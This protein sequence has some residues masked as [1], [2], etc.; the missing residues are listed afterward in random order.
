[1]WSVA[2][3]LFRK[4]IS[5]D[6]VIPAADILHELKIGIDNEMISI[7]EATNRYVRILNNHPDTAPI[8]KMVLH[9]G[10]LVPIVEIYRTS[11]PRISVY[12]GTG[13]IWEND[14]SATVHQGHCVCRH[15]GDCN[16][17]MLPYRHAKP[18]RSRTIQS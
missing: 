4:F 11:Y 2:R 7:D 9:E 3:W 13:T 12:C 15:I 1:M 5:S 17:G 8:V 6:D 14:H 16:L 10:E 18:V